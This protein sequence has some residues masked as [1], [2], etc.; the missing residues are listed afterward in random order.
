MNTYGEIFNCENCN[1]K[2]VRGSKEDNM[3]SLCNDC[4]EE[5]VQDGE[6]KEIIE[7]AF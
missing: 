6:A 2:I 1:V 5:A 3:T 4:L 7:E